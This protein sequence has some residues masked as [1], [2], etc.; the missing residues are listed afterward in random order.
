MLSTNVSFEPALINCDIVNEGRLW[1]VHPLKVALLPG[2]CKGHY[3][4]LA[5]PGADRS[6]SQGRHRLLNGGFREKALALAAAPS[7][8]PA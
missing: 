8:H 3:L 2:L 4:R 5:A 7:L 1:A 6:I